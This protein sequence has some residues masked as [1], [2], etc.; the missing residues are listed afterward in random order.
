MIIVIN[1]IKFKCV[2]IYDKFDT[3]VK[4]N[5]IIIITPYVIA[6]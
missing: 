4:N 3:V 2:Q 6:R 5:K 1:S